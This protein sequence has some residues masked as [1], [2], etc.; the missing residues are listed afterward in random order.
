MTTEILA[1]R[2]TQQIKQ[3]AMLLR[4]A[5]LREQTKV[6][7]LKTALETIIRIAARPCVVDIAEKA[8]EKV[9]R[10]DMFNKE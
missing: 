1:K 3:D 6:A 5:Y 2:W 4:D 9:K 10:A 7:I 8:L